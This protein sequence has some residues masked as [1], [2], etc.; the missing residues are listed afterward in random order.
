MLT[1]F[2]P[3]LIFSFSA[4]NPSILFSLKQIIRDVIDYV[5]NVISGSL[6]LEKDRENGNDMLHRIV[7]SLSIGHI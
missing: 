4:S 2:A 3:W 7:L 5:L 6:A 1:F